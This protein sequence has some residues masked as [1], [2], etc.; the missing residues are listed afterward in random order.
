MTWLDAVIAVLG[1]GTLASIGGGI[2]FVW[3]KIDARFTAI[4]TKLKQCERRDRRSRKQ[5]GLLLSAVEILLAKI[6]DLAPEAA[7]ITRARELLEQHRQLEV[8]SDE[9]G[10]QTEREGSE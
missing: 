2:A 8:Q 7:V 3:N 10:L 6:Q 9:Q 4:E 5:I 1:G